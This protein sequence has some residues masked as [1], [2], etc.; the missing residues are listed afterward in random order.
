MSRVYVGR[1]G[2]LV[3]PQRLTNW[4]FYAYRESLRQWGD[5]GEP[6]LCALKYLD[7]HRPQGRS[8]SR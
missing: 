2:F 3:R 6:V 1:D 8:W 7:V 4:A 5:T